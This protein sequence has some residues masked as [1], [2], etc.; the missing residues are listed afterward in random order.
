M[1]DVI[2]GLDA[3]LRER[4]AAKHDP[5]REQQAREWIEQVTGESFPEDTSFLVA[6][7]DGVILC[8]LMNTLRPGTIK[9]RASR[10]PFIQMENIN[11]FL[12]GARDL[13]CP[14]ADLFQTVDLYEEKNPPQVV[15][16][17]FSVSRHAAKAGC[18]V[19]ILGPRLSERHEVQFT[20]EQLN[21]GKGV[22]NT[23]Q[24]GYYEGAS[25]TGMNFG[26]RREISGTYSD[27]SKRM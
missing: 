25:Q 27:G 7:R 21:A 13:G 5:V 16:A 15:D 24:Y 1:T 17:I 23:A 9:Y 8:K 20:D 6:L 22:I 19:P 11:K 12:E 4:L 2:Q 26:K 14:A 3:D 18:D 10:M